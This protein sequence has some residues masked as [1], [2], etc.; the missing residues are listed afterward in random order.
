MSLWNCCVKS[1]AI[2]S[3][4][5]V[6]VLFDSWRILSDNN[7]SSLFLKSWNKESAASAKASFIISQS[8]KDLLWLVIEWLTCNN[9]SVAAFA[10][11]FRCVK[12]DYCPINCDF[13]SL[14]FLFFSSL[15]GGKS[16]LYFLWTVRKCLSTFLMVVWQIRQ[17][18][19]FLVSLLLLISFEA[20]NQV[21]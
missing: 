1:L 12:N 15:F 9:V 20:A 7:I 8:G 5:C 10:C 14:T 6:T 16:V 4:C 3:Q 18:H 2:T 19:I 13:S 11:E 21:P 17:M